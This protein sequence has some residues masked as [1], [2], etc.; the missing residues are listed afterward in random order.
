[1]EYKP[2]LMRRWIEE[3]NEGARILGIRW[4]LHRQKGWQ[5][6]HHSSSTWQKELTLHVGFAWVGG[7]SAPLNTSGTDDFSGSFI[8]ISHF[9]FLPATLLLLAR[10][11]IIFSIFY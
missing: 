3:D 1:M 8:I 9:L 7:S 5:T 11:L 4:L 10:G 2:G 6:R